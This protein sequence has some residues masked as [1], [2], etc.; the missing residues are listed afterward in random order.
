M[1][2]EGFGC[3]SC[4]AKKKEFN[5]VKREAGTS[6][7]S[8]LAPGKNAGPQVL[9]G[10]PT[11][12]PFSFPTGLEVHGCLPAV[13][14]EGCLPQKVGDPKVKHQLLGPENPMALTSWTKMGPFGMLCDLRSWVDFHCPEPRLYVTHCYNK[15]LTMKPEEI[16]Q[17]PHHITY[18]DIEPFVF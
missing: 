13:T 3:A 5:T 14:W 12:Q 7:G 2:L 16:N 10:T 1:P 4:V 17:H 8:D 18:W 9:I 6:T 11:A 15:Q